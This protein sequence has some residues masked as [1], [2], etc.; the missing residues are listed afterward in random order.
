MNFSQLEDGAAI[1]VSPSVLVDFKFGNKRRNRPSKDYDQIKASIEA[2]GILQNLVTRPHPEDDTKLELLAGYGR[3][4]IAIDLALVEARAL[5]E[6]AMFIWSG[7][8]HRV[9]CIRL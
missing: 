4:D 3:K 6:C 2:Q 5:M 9:C 1:N 7:V 8:W